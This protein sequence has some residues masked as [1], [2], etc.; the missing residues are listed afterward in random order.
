M[1]FLKKKQLIVTKEN[2]TVSDEL[3]RVKFG[4]E[5]WIEKENERKMS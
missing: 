1:D 5:G 2:L 4:Q 3:T